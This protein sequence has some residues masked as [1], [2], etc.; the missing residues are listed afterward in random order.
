MIGNISVHNSDSH[1][2]QKSIVCVIGM[3]RSGTSAIARG[4]E[5]LGLQ[6]GNAL[7]APG[8]DNP[9]GYWEDKD[10]LEINKEIL[11][12]ADV[13]WNDVRILPDSLFIEGPLNVYVDR[14]KKLLESRI[15]QYPNWGFKDPRTLRVLPYWL[16]AA[17]QADIGLKF[18]V[19]LRHPYAVAESLHKRNGISRVRGQL[20][21]G[22]YVLPFL[23]LIRKYPHV[24]I[25]YDGLLHDPIINVN[26]MAE[27]L[28]LGVDNKKLEIYVENFLSQSL[29]H[30]SE[31][32]RESGLSKQ[33]LPVTDELYHILMAMNKEDDANLWEHFA[34]RYEEYKRYQ[35]V[36]EE[37]D[38]ESD[39]H[40]KRRGSFIKRLF[41]G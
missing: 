14:A 2:S 35:G 36:L 19:A 10:V 4:L 15:K 7:I 41:Y 20:M 18:V 33:V 26:K 25:S 34:V 17:Q 40:W 13:A 30:H 6:M 32:P 27:M 16:Q 1:Q 37:L 38:A 28:A 31:P 23:S 8:D 21:W 24:F 29:K 9:K 11:E 12:V 3:H 22:A 39:Y 5:C